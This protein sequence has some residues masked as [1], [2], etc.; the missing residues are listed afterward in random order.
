MQDRGRALTAAA[1]RVVIG[2]EDG[3]RVRSEVTEEGLL[4]Y[5]FGPGPG[6]AI[7]GLR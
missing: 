6:S 2:M 3:F 4:L 5:E 1:E 7:P